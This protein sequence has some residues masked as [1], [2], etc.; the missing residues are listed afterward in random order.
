VVALSFAIAVLGAYAKLN[1]AEAVTAARGARVAWL[2]GGAT[3]LK[4]VPSPL[5]FVYEHA[6]AIAHRLCRRIWIL[7]Q[8]PAF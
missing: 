3:P 6:R 8:R 5:G 4:P 2:I 7:R 1:L